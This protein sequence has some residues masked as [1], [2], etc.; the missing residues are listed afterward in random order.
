MRKQILRIM[1]E[2]WEPVNP[3]AEEKSAKGTLPGQELP[4]END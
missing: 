1:A 4:G 2:R 3:E